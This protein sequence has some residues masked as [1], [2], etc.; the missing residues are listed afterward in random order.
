MFRTRFMEMFGLTHPVMS[1]PMALHSGGE[2]AAAVSGAGGW[3]SFGG[4]HPAK[5]PDWIRAEIATIRAS[6]DRPFAVGFI[7][8]FLAFTE[9]LFDAALAE[10]PA[11]VAFSFADPGPWIDRCKAA[12]ARVIC[13]VQNYE[14]ADLAVAGGTD[15][16]V[17]QGTE[18]GG[19]TGTM[20][21]LPFLAGVAA[22]YPDVPVLAAGGIA[23]GRTLAA[24]LIAGADGAWLGTAFLATPEAVEVPDINKRLIV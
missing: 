24:A 8:P 14:D 20:S 10:R 15:V 13:Q 7:T 17:A 3:G 9:P 1:A 16:L 23:D 11:A 19:H 12:G 2:L 21:L 6:T 18:A 5:G 4:T 22:R